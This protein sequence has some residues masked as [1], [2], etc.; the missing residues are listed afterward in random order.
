MLGAGLVLG[1]VAG[2]CSFCALG[3]SVLSCGGAVALECSGARRRVTIALPQEP[4]CE[5]ASDVEDAFP[6]LSVSS[7]NECT[8]EGAAEL[9]RVGGG[10]LGASM[11]D[12]PVVGDKVIGGEDIVPVVRLACWLLGF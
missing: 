3:G 9:K 8:I 2:S 4:L 10:R 6:T 12:G 1:F 11:L 5:R 7:C